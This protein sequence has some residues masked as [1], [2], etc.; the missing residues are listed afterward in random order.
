M[1][2]EIGKSYRDTIGRKWK[3]IKWKIVGD[4]YTVFLVR[5]RF[6]TEIAVQDSSDK[7]TILLDYGFSTIWG[8]R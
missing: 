6:K 1:T 8:F 4:G 2:F 7:A 3:I 5:R